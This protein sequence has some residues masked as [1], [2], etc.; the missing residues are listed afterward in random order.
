MNRSIVRAAWS[1][2]PLLAI[3]GAAPVSAGPISYDLTK[4]FSFQ[5]GVQGA[6]P[7][8]SGQYYVHAIEG[9]QGASDPKDQ[10]MGY[11]VLA[12]D[13][14][15]FNNILLGKPVKYN[16]ATVDL[17]LQVDPAKPFST[18]K[19]VTVGQS[20]AKS[21]FKVTS[22][23]NQVA[24]GTVAVSGSTKDGWAF[25]SAKLKATVG[26]TPIKG[27]ITKLAVDPKM[28]VTSTA[29]NLQLISSRAGVSDPLNFTVTDSSGDVLQS[30]KLFTSS[31][32]V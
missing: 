10:P 18:T 20:T 3:L 19:P 14:G 7:I 6:N 26:E 30:Q 27:T 25:S 16:L 32:E 4:G 11:D 31:A 29:P 8:L 1:I 24:N 12:I 21:A 9:N 15:P 13:G 28:N 22:L 2:A 5:S 17:P 23:G